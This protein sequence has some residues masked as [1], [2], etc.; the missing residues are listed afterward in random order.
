MLKSKALI[1]IFSFL[2]SAVL[3]AQAPKTETPDPKEHLFKD[4]TYLAFAPPYVNKD[5]FLIEYG[6][7]VQKQLKEIKYDYNAYVVASLF[8]DW[9]DK[10]GDLKAGGLGFKVGALFPLIKS[11]PTS[12]KVGAGFA[13]T[14]LHKN[15][16]FGKTESAVAKKDMGILEAGLVFRYHKFF[17]GGTYQ[18]SNVKYFTRHVF[19]SFGVNY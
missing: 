5:Y 2:F 6:F 10:D 14:T 15:P 3:Y 19:I 12:L 1:L 17:V 11:F 13:K 16:I 8:E 7:V 18:F 4:G 9:K